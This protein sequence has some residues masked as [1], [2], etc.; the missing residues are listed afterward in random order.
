MDCAAICRMAAAYMARGSDFAVQMCRLCAEICTACAAECGKHRMDHCQA[1]AQ[2]C[3]R[4]AEAC[5]AMIG[6]A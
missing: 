2:A 4:C 6:R 1:C 3:T 5:E